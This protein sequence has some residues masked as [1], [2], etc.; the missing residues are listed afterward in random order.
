MNKKNILLAFLSFAFVITANSQKPSRPATTKKQVKSKPSPVKMGVQATYYIKN[1]HIMLRWAPVNEESWRYG[2][3]YG[4]VLERRTIVRDEKL[5]TGPEQIKS[6]QSFP[7]IKDSL[8]HWEKVAMYNDNAA[9]M[10]Q[11]IYGESFE[12]DINK[13]GN[14]AA[15]GPSLLSKAEEN[16]Q[17]FLFGLYAADNDFTVASRAGLGYIDTSV[18]TNEKYFYRIYS[19][20][21]KNLVTKDT[22]LLFVSFQDIA[23]LPQTADIYIEPSNNSLVLTWDMERTKS[24]Y[25]SFIIQRSDDGGKTFK[26]ITR[27]PYSSMGQ[28]NNPHMPNSVMFVDTAVQ[29]GSTYKYRVGGLS[30]FGEKGPWSTIAEAKTLPLLDG[31][32]GIQGIRLNTQGDALV[33]W[34][35]EDSIRPKISGFEVNHSPTQDGIYKK[36]IGNIG[37]TASEVKIPDTVAAGYLIVKAISKEGISRTS[38]P[39]LYQPEDSIPPSA[40]IGVTAKIDTTGRVE[41][42]WLPNSEKDLLGYKVFRTMVKG[43]EHAVLVD[44]IWSSNI[45]YDTLDLKLKNRKVYYTVTALDFRSNQSSMSKEIEVIKPDIIPPTPPVFSDYKLK[46]KAV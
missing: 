3:K 22:A 34:Y 46:D 42:K 32:P 29:T 16:K 44:T 28:G 33:N 27:R 31:V 37:A 12:V 20:A 43:T 40:P 7:F 19:A 11:A 36:I 38:F 41:L 13:T 25:N 45:F 17:R 9:V 18:K 21:P 8:V 5:L 23:Q 24:Y 4:Y 14:V 1:N 10:A 39:Y 15:S 35:F 2:S 26:S 6:F 30:I